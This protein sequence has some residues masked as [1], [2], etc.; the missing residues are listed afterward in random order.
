[1]AALTSAGPTATNQL[2]SKSPEDRVNVR[3][4][5]LASYPSTYPSRPHKLSWSDAHGHNAT[6]DA[7]YGRDSPKPA[8]QSIFSAALTSSQPTK[9]SS[10]EAQSSINRSS[11]GTRDSR[12]RVSG[13]KFRESGS[14]DQLADSGPWSSSPELHKI[15]A[16]ILKE[17]RVHEGFSPESGTTALRPV[18]RKSRRPGISLKEEDVGSLPR[19]VRQPNTKPSANELGS[20]SRL[21]PPEAE[22]EE[23]QPSASSTAGIHPDEKKETRLP[24]ENLAIP[25]RNELQGRSQ[26]EVEAYSEGEV[27]RSTM[28]D[29][30][31]QRKG[32]HSARNKEVCMPPD[33]DGDSESCSTHGM[34]NSLQTVDSLLKQS[35]P[36]KAAPHSKSADPDPSKSNDAMVPMHNREIEGVYKQTEGPRPP[37]KGEDDQLNDEFERL[38][39]AILE[40]ETRILP[41][42]MQSSNGDSP[43]EESLSSADLS[44]DVYEDANHYSFPSSD[45]LQSASKDKIS[46]IASDSV[47]FT[48]KGEQSVAVEEAN[49]SR[50]LPIVS[51]DMTGLDSHANHDLPPQAGIEF[52]DESV[53]S[54]LIDE[55]G[56]LHVEQ[57]TEEGEPS[58]AAAL[59]SVD[60]ATSLRGVSPDFRMQAT[61]DNYRADDIGS[62]AS[63]SSPHFDGMSETSFGM[64]DISGNPWLRGVNS[65]GPIPV[66][67]R[68]AVG[69]SASAT[70]A[71][72]SPLTASGSKDSPMGRSPYKRNRARRSSSGQRVDKADVDLAPRGPLPRTPSD[73]SGV[74]NDS[75]SVSL[76]PPTP[77]LKT[78][79]ST[80]SI[81]GTMGRRTAS[82]R[83][84]LAE[85]SSGGSFQGQQSRTT[86][87]SS[88]AVPA[89]GA[90]IGNVSPSLA[91]SPAR[92][93]L[94]HSPLRQTSQQMPL[95]L[96]KL[97]S[98]PILEKAASSSSLKS[99]TSE[100][101][102]RPPTN[103][104]ISYDD[105]PT[106]QQ[107]SPSLRKGKEQFSP[108]PAQRPSF[109]GADYALLD[110]LQTSGLG[111]AGSSAA[112]RQSAV[113]AEPQQMWQGVPRGTIDHKSSVV[114]STKQDDELTSVGE[115]EDGDGGE[116]GMA[117][118]AVPLDVKRNRRFSGQKEAGDP[119]TS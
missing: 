119:G 76:T 74:L 110:M 118:A 48:S 16:Q 77:S 113:V 22:K 102:S 115:G 54:N 17:P 116:H 67:S 100:Q 18:P 104:S 89:P 29:E 75:A 49:L 33:Q 3:P 84:S 11:G 57:N 45:E 81:P 68:S 13:G 83:A 90:A 21:Q 32:K 98:S 112:V 55:R 99:A 61:F 103:R 52:V 73:R 37:S 40:R 87:T 88:G 23:E 109:D 107:P 42:Q 8:Y 70:G 47:E 36:L 38:P 53:L 78:A 35:A 27:V 20:A 63:R 26:K 60:Q 44:A 80:G 39:K 108:S 24:N 41:G 7:A 15:S 46:G 14:S 5:R 94:Q 71:V 117:R 97:H 69:S 85:L 65:V 51:S 34:Q 10:G 93:L 91:Q 12:N 58:L 4:Y 64:R 101:N 25:A 111:K 50:P 59:E 72:S 82:S 114:G 28:S 19:K 92:A 95:G 79:D 105:A 2:R 1:M 30:D 96:K 86:S 56:F 6:C 66:T 106:S 43:L 9:H 62:E 31:R